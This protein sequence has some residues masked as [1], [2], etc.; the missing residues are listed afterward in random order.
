MKLLCA[1]FNNDRDGEL[2]SKPI[3]YNHLITII[4]NRCSLGSKKMDSR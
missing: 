4:V 3:R 1:T 2:W